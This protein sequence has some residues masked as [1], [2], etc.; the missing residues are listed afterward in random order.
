M[1][2]VSDHL[3]DKDYVAF[4]F[5]FF[6]GTITVYI[7]SYISTTK[8]TLFSFVSESLDITLIR[9]NSV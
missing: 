9:N 6:L 7:K 5:P 2:I 4:C 8:I 3:D 1:I